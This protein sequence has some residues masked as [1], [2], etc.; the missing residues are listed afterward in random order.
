M[1]MKENY[2]QF[3]FKFNISSNFKSFSPK[4]IVIGKIDNKKE[5]EDG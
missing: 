1:K 4:Y 5:K 3:N 2:K